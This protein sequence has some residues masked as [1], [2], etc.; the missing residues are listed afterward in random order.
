MATP[1]D[2]AHLVSAFPNLAKENFAIV[3]PPC[4]RYNCLA[5]AVGDTGQPWS[6][7]PPDYWPPEVP[8]SPT[9]AGLERLFRWLGFKKCGGPRLETGYQK[10]ALYGKQGEWTHAALQTPNGRW[11][12]K[13]GKGE[14]IE[15]ETPNG[16]AGP[17]AIDRSADRYGPGVYGV[18]RSN[19]YKYE[20]SYG[21]SQVYMI[22]KRKT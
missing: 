3:C 19:R 13:L 2:K 1:S 16:V 21:R 7:V 18:D 14:L 15:H 6:N 10:V 17:A 20:E 12:S 11:R 8:R 4:E 22:R 9:V 5:Y